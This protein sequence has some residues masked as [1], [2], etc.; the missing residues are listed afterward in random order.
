MK[1]IAK[2]VTKLQLSG[3][4]KIFNLQWPVVQEMTKNGR[5]MAKYILPIYECHQD[6]GILALQFP[7]Y[8]NNIEILQCP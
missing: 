5:K 1:N 6:R 2:I 4:S 7:I 3:S 8:I